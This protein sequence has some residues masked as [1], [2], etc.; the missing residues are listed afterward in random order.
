MDRYDQVKDRYEQV[1]DRYE[2]T[3]VIPAPYLVI[4][5]HTCPIPGPTFPIPCPTCQ[6]LLIP[7]P[8]LSYLS[9]PRILHLPF[10]LSMF[11]PFCHPTPPSIHIIFR[12]HHPNKPFSFM[13]IALLPTA[14]ESTQSYWTPH[15]RAQCIKFY[16]NFPGQLATIQSG[17]AWPGRN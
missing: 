14:P 17:I 6:I 15:P 12:L 7:V 2:H 16:A 5:A 1:W 10:H 4:P 9:T 13:P 11:L 3:M 8:Y